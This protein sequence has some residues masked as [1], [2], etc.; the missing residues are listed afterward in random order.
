M[1]AQVAKTRRGGAVKCHCS[2]CSRQ[3]CDRSVRL[4][5]GA[6]LAAAVLVGATV[7]SRTPVMRLRNLF[8]N[9]STLSLKPF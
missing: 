4:T 2:Y 5:A 1:A 7:R 3:S 9:N 8:W 6:T